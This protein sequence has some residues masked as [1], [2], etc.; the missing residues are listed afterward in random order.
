MLPI[1]P[2]LATLAAEPPGELS[3]LVGVTPAGE[4]HH[5]RLARLPHLL[6]AGTSGSGKTV[7]LYGLLLSLL[8]YRGPGQ[9][10]LLLVDP[11]QTDFAFF[12]GLPHLEAG[13]VV[14]N[15]EEA[16]HHL[17]HLLEEEL[18]SRTNRLRE[19]RARDIHEYSRQA[20]VP[21]PPIVVVIDEYADLVDVL[22][23]RDREEFEQQVN[24]MAQRTR[25]VDIH[26]VIATQRPDVKVV[27]GRL[28]S[29]LN[30][31][32]SFALPSA[33]DSKTILDVGG[34]ERL[35]GRGDLLM[36]HEDKLTRL[37]GYYVSGQ[38]LDAH[39]AQW[40]R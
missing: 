1:E 37:Q 18:P 26:L 6:V 2:A 14:L 35:L 19:V 17:Q 23:K 4:P 11:K 21:M 13:G 29:N 15:S 36:R 38:D 10:R 33:V 24:R 27:T 16:I 40:R 20:S 3:F 7:F 30:C 22:N 28:K 31:R 9:L 32:I 5:L 8:T 34:A 39:L 25:N 12:E